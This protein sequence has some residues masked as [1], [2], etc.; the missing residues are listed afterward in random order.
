[1][2]KPRIKV[3]AQ[4]AALLTR[5]FGKHLAAFEKR[6]PFNK[7]QLAAHRATIS[8][9]L[10]AG[11]VART[12]RN[13]RFFPQLYETLKLWKIGVRRSRLVPFELDPIWWTG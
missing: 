9:R 13:D 5:G 11:T 1:M 3:M 8:L 10:E 4:R 2:P 6:P 12:L 7:P